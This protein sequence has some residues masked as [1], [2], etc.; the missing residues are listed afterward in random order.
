[1]SE[2]AQQQAVN[3]GFSFN[4]MDPNFRLNPYPYLRP[5]L[6]APPLVMR[7]FIPVAVLARYDDV[8]LAIRDHQR[9]SS[10]PTRGLSLPSQ[11]VFGT[12]ANLVATDPPIH[13]RLR[14]IVS[15]DFTPRKIREMEPRIREITNALL[16]PL[17]E[18]G[19][20]DLVEDLAAT[21]PLHVVASLLGIPV[22]LYGNFKR[23]SQSLIELTSLTLGSGMTD[24]MR[25][26]FIEMRSYFADEIERRRRNPGVDLISNLVAARADVE[27]LTAD[28]LMQFL[29][30][31][32]MAGNETTT[33]FLGNAM[34][35]LGRHPDQMDLLRREP[36]LLP[37]AIEEM[38]RYDGPVM[39]LFRTAKENLTVGGTEIEKNSGVL[40]LLG[41]ANRDP[42]H[43]EKPDE[44]D[45]TRSPNE[46]LAFG[47]GIHF[48]LGA[49]LARLES[50][51]A[52]STMLNR[53]PKLRVQTEVDL[54]YKTSFFF[55]GLHS[56]RVAVE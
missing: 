22:E 33:N 47:D 48:C 28:E 8:L 4:P 49:P 11:Q 45:I 29:I 53:F 42:L 44:F 21:L 41:A 37:R 52:I 39:A 3:T 50:C 34:L 12:A 15:A 32:L 56:L 14:K 6:D 7:L 13:S 27:M 5:L 23:W 38:L 19:E 35:A 2:G 25:D 54:A 18:K 10:V 31:L 40:V 24:A 55:R 17:E 43:F 51:I 16:D 26:D 1:M 9:F 30:V 36:A 46:H 20:F